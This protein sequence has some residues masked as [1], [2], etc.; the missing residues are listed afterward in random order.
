MTL[1]SL[2]SEL[3]SIRAHGMT[4]TNV[5][6]VEVTP[7]G[8]ILDADDR[9]ADSIADLKGDLEA[10]SAELKQCE[11]ERDGL[12]AEIDR[13][14][15]EQMDAADLAEELARFRGRA[16]DWAKAHEAMQHELTAL[17]KRKGVAAGVCAYSHEIRT[18]LAYISQS[19]D[20]RYCRDASELH[21]KIM[22]V[23]P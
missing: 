1:S 5:A 21:R 7:H 14:T 9:D 23:S 22:E 16:S 20:N 17:R 13:L 6:A 19:K 15:T 3:D 18:L 12:Q 4:E 10:T 2:R 8:V 11:A